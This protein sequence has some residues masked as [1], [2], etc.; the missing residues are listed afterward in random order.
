IAANFGTTVN[1]RGFDLFSKGLWIIWGR[2][3]LGMRSL[4][5]FMVLATLLVSVFCVSLR[6]TS[7]NET[8]PSEI[9]TTPSEIETTP[10]ED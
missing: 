4:R 3:N 6:K 8:A 10:Q 2:T 9:E 7:K 1:D 5:Y